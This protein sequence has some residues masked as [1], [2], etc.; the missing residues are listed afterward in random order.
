[1]S[2]IH[3]NPKLAEPRMPFILSANAEEEWLGSLDAE[4]ATIQQLILPAEDGVLEAHTV[5]RLSGKDYKGNNAKVAERE[6]YSALEG[7]DQM[8]LFG[9]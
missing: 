3:N 5:G 6:S 8:A 4:I 9:K 1:M 7:G 2:G